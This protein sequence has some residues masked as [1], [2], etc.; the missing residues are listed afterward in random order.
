MGREKEGI[1]REG[2]KDSRIDGEVEQKREKESEREM[3]KLR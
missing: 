3:G 1:V 2:E